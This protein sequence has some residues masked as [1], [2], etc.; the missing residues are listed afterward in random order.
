MSGDRKFTR[1]RDFCKLYK[2]IGRQD[3]NFRKKHATLARSLE[4]KRARMQAQ[5]RDV[6]GINR[7]IQHHESLSRR[8]STT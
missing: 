3:S 4:K 5:G 1:N 7:A 6:A 8:Q 2:A